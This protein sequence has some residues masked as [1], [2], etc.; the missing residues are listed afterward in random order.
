MFIRDFDRNDVL[1]RAIKIE[2][3]VLNKDK[4]KVVS[5]IQNDFGYVICYDQHGTDNA[6]E[7]YSPTVSKAVGIQKV[8]DH[9]HLSRE[10]SY[11]FG[12]GSNDM[13]MI[14]YCGTGVAMGNAVQELKDAADIVCPSIEDNGLEI[15]LKELFPN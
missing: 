7:L 13:E 10:D 11:A 9:F 12:D 5:Y 15:I 4:E 3:N 2:A 1:K 6:F 8:L 14:Q